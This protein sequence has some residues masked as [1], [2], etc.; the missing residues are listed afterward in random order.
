MSEHDDDFAAAGLPEEW[1]SDQTLENLKMERS[2]RPEETNEQMTRR[3]LEEAAPAAAQ[4]IIHLA[5]HSPN[6]NTRLNAAK[7][8]T[9]SL[10]ESDSSGGKAKWE[11]L[12]GT[13]VSEVEVYANQG[14]PSDGDESEEEE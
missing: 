4:S 7:Y 5:L 2:V 6:D 3:L 13:A 11:E 14:A 9:D 1:N 12:I 8:V 10:L